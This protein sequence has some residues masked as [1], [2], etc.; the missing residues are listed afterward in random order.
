MNGWYFNVT[1]TPTTCRSRLK[2]RFSDSRGVK[3]P[4]KGCNIKSVGAIAGP[5]GLGNKIYMKLL[6]SSNYASAAPIF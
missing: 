3:R 6:G 4:R 5:G 2:N 1:R